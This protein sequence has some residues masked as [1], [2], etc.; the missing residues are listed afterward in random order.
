MKAIKTV[1]KS[2]Y[3]QFL[4][5]FSALSKLDHPNIVKL[6][7]VYDDADNSHL[8]LEFCEGGDLCSYIHKLEVGL[9]E[10]KAARIIQ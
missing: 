6:Y 8:L 9:E 7:N 10:K 3:D 2:H 5:E 1:K 4:N